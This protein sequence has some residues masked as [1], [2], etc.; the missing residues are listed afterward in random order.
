M[1]TIEYSKLR[2]EEEE[3]LVKILEDT[4]ALKSYYDIFNNEEELK[5]VVNSLHSTGIKLNKIIAPRLY[6]ICSNV[7]NI[8]NYDEDID[9][10]IISSVEFNAYSINGFGYVPHMICL[11]SSLV[12]IFTDE[13]LS[14]VIGHEIGHLMF[15]HSQ[16]LLV[17]HLITSSK[18]RKPSAQ[19]LNLFAR[20]NKY[21]EISSDRA[22]YIAQPDLGTI[23]K[24]FFKL[25]S[26]LSEEHLNFNIAEYMKQLEYIKEMPRSEFYAS[27]PNHL[28]RLKCLELFSKSILY[29][30]CP[31][32]QVT[33]KDLLAETYDILGLLE[34]HP[35]NEDQK[36]A[37]EFIASVGMYVA[38]ADEKINPKESESLYNLLSRYTSQPEIYL[39]FKDFQEVIERKNAICKYYVQTKNDLK[40]NLFEQAVYIAVCDGKLDEPEKNLL[41]EIAN[42]LQIDENRRNQIILNISYH[43]M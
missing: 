3:L 1:R 18:S 9:F 37:V 42:R 31:E 17:N 28:V 26:G 38:L 19:I 23:G 33:C 8:L 21:A 10:Y 15:K 30:K 5:S 4:F 12:Q 39:A 22:G 20:W 40:Y 14:F 35:Q 2:F 41:I 36:C 29:P 34:Y 43:Y 7:K 11:T 6:Q 13:E 24:V 27:H 32:S 16:L 25:A